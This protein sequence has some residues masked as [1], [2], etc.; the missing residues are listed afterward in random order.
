[1]TIATF[2]SSARGL[3]SR[4]ISTAFLSRAAWPFVSLADDYHKSGEVEDEEGGTSRPGARGCTRRVSP[5]WPAPR[6]HCSR[7]ASRWGGLP[8]EPLKI[9]TN[10]PLLQTAVKES[11]SVRNSVN[12][13]GTLLIGRSI[14]CR[15]R[16]GIRTEPS[17][18]LSSL[19]DGVVSPRN[20]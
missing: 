18:R 11:T 10:L 15:L 19:R 7:A 2:P 1:M 13:H 4:S 17:G 6:P 16:V 14:R 12:S 8:E 20:H 3:Y 9:T 5:L